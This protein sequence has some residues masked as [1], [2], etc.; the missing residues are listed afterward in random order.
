MVPEGIDE[1][2]VVVEINDKSAAAKSELKKGDIILEL[3]GSKVTNS[4]YL[5]YLLYKYNPGETVKVTYSRNGKIA[6]TNIT[7]SKNEE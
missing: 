6:T 2:V 4:A 7:L 5:K 3:N 1:G